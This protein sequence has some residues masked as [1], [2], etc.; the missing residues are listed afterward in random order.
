MRQAFW[1]DGLFLRLRDDVV[2]RGDLERASSTTVELGERSYRGWSQDH[3][4]G[5]VFGYIA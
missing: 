2:M 4:L 1:D 3:Q 5:S